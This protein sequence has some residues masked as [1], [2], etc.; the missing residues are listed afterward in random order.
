[1][2]ILALLVALLQ[3]APQDTPGFWKRDTLLD[4]AG[5]GRST[6]SERGVTF[7]LAFTGEF[8]SN[9]HGG[10]H[11]DSGCD[12][13]LDWVLDA[14]L[15]K[16]IGWPGATAR[17]NPMWIVGDGVNADVGDLTGV[18]N[19][20]GR[21]GV[22]IYEAWLEQS[23]FD[24]VLSIRAGILAADQ[25][26]ILS[27]A[28]MLYYNS[29]F[30][31]PVFLSPNLRWP[32]YPLGALGARINVALTEDVYVR[33]AAYDGDPG[34][35]DANRSGLRTRLANGEG[36]FAISEAGWTL[37]KEKSLTLKAGGFHHS[38]K[39][40]DFPSGSTKR[41]L[42]GGYVAAE[43]VICRDFSPIGSCKEGK[44]DVFFRSGLAQDDRALVFFGTDAGVN[45]T[46]L[47]PGRPADVLGLGVIYARISRQFA[48]TQSDTA[49]WGHETIFEATYKVTLTPWWS[50]QP[51]LQ[52]VIHPG[53]STAIPNAT[54]VGV[55]LDLLF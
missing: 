29:V 46:G 14:D 51:D 35:E 32:I 33:A 28:G 26:F 38:G 11:Q 21:G 7:T 10:V 54:V 30:G 15:K 4:D 1:M 49:A 44:I 37:D 25:E 55:R 48:D 47:I 22:R 41:G 34:S 6:L 52:Y 39:F 2:G 43:H 19:I 27:N 8:I 40:V 12:M 24:D 36:V 50:L 53:G 13:L 45:V 20:S 42:S 31:G 18:S 3:G 16:A 9:M 23:L 5:G 17:V